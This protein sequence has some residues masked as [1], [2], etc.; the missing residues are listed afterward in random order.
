[1]VQIALPIADAERC[2]ANRQAEPRPIARRPPARARVLP[3][4]F[5]QLAPSL[6]RCRLIDSRRFY[7]SNFFFLP[8]QRVRVREIERR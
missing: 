4:A 2:S 6:L 8:A 1:M 7:M 5:Q 3:R